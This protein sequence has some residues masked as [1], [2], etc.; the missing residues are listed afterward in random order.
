[1]TNPK[2]SDPEF[3]ARSTAIKLSHHG[4]DHHQSL[5][6]GLPDDIAQ[7][8]LSLVSPS[9]L[10]SVCRSWRRLIYSASFPA[11]LSLYAVVLPD[12]QSQLEAT[13]DPVDFYS[14]DPISRLWSSLPPPPSDPPPRFLFRHPAFIR[15]NLP[16]QSVS[17]AGKLIVLAAT[18]DQFLPALSHPLLFDPL[19]GSW[20]RGPQ[21]A[22]PRRWCAV[23]SAGGAVYVASGMG[24]GY[25]CDVARTIERWNLESIPDPDLAAARRRRTP[26]AWRRMTDMKDGKFS[27]DA[28]EAVGW[29]GRLCM[30]NVKGTAAKEG[31]VYDLARDC[32]REMPA[33][34]L[35]GWRGPAAGLDE[36][37]IY[38][39]DEGRGVLRRYDGDRDSW[40]DVAGCGL[41]R[42]AQQVAA[43]GGRVCV[44]CADGTRIVVVDVASPP[45]ARMWVEEVPPGVQVVGI[46]IM[47]RLVR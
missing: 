28:I 25:S 11:Y 30:V 42:G 23:G 41:F 36:E 12:G 16:I 15:R 46:H 34:M 21:L 14:F 47:P 10:Y 40:E 19:S 45:P 13:P 29:R 7:L 35:A 33:G 38:L 26:P 6:P 43:G 22:A 9:I 27:R 24:A 44:L 1:M 20:S 5:L 39:V 3:S 31:V 37:T 32:W 2:S 8:C 17:A 4:G 18:D